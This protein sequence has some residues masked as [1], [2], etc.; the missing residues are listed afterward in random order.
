MI[1]IYRITPSFMRDN[2]DRFIQILKQKNYQY[3]GPKEFMLD[4]P[5]KWDFSFAASD[6]SNGDILVGFIICSQKTTFLL[7]EHKLFVDP[8]YQRQGIGKMLIRKT[9]RHAAE[10]GVTDY[11]LN[12]YPDSESAIAL[13]D[14]LGMI[15]MNAVKDSIGLRYYYQGLV[16]L[17]LKSIEGKYE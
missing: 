7:H 11:A 14:K 13:Y 1:S 9:L 15:R 2:M 12:V 6:S 17:I 5:G 4:L 3:W 10:A 8:L 16:S